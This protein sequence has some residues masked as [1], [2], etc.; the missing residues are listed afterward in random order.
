MSYNAKNY[1]E[2]GGDKTVIGGELEIKE[3]ARVTGLP[4]PSITPA[5]Y[6]A[7]SEATTVGLL[8]ADFN[9]LLANLKAAGLVASEETA[10][11]EGDA[12]IEENE[13]E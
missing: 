1:T 8:R 3:G 13:T 5:A 9:T 10:V 4:S 7:A 12:V 11:G 2:P 6:Q